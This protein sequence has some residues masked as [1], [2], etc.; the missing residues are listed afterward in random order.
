MD[1]NDPNVA[2]QA[3]HISINRIIIYFGQKYPDEKTSVKEL[4]DAMTSYA[5]ASKE[6][7]DRHFQQLNDQLVATTVELS[8]C[9]SNQEQLDGHV[10]LVSNALHLSNTAAKKT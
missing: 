1:E 6:I 7:S 9:A 8:G 5:A 2:Q 3:A 10:A 4:S